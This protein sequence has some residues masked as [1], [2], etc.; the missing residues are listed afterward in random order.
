MTALGRKEDIQKSFPLELRF[1]S[2]I[3]GAA[4]HPRRWRRQTLRRRPRSRRW[5]LKLY[6]DLAEM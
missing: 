5:L 6:N 4:F 2:W 1:V 3:E